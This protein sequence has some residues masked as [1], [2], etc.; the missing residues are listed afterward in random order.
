MKKEILAHF[1]EVIEQISQYM[2]KFDD[3]IKAMDEERK[4]ILEAKEKGEAKLQELRNLRA[5]VEKKM[6]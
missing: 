2:G 3:H 5:E 6:K 1:D 4:K